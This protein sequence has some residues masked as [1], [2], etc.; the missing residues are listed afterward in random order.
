MLPRAEESVTLR[1]FWSSRVKSGA[2]SP[3]A[4]GVSRGFRSPLLEEDESSLALQEMLA[5]MS[6]IAAATL[7]FISLSPYKFSMCA[8][9]DS[10]LDVR[11]VPH[12]HLYVFVS[13]IL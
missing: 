9:R 12:R 8:R 7:R 2:F 4:T 11:R 1:L 5:M 3:T 6:V 13:L 10:F